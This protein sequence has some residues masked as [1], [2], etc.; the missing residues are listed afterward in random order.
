MWWDLTRPVRD[1]M[2][3]FTEGAYTDVPV[4]ISGWST[5]D[6]QGYATQRLVLGTQSGTHIDAPAHFVD[7]AATLDA[8][9]AAAGVGRFRLVTAAE[10]PTARFEPG[11]IPLLDVRGP[12]P[13]PPDAADRLDPRDTPLL[14]LLGE[15]V[16]AGPD[17]YAVNRGCAR[18]GVFL[19]EDLDDR[20]FPAGVTT[21]PILVA[22][23]R[24][25]GT[26]GA[27]CRV[28]LG[29]PDTPH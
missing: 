5:V 28:L 4:R 1:G 12:E 25:V 2:D 26:S 24:L 21:G 20:E 16:C 18:R 9:P 11:L 14:V 8:L 13:L 10:L 7:G 17:R 27:P 23:P 6:G 29:S 15:A 22:W 19:V 3:V